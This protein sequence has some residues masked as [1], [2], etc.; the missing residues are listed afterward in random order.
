MQLYLTTMMVLPEPGSWHVAYEGCRGFD[1]NFLRLSWKLR[2]TLETLQQA[3]SPDL[4]LACLEV[5]MTLWILASSFDVTL[6]LQRKVPN[7]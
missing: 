1:F 6:T 3:N 7:M 5:Y 2:V 4:K